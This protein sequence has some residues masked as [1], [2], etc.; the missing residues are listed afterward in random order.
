MVSILG[1]PAPGG[2]K[3]GRVLRKN[4]KIVM[5]ADGSGPVV[6]VH[7]SSKGTKPWMDTVAAV[8][9]S[10]WGDPEVR[11]PVDGPVEA[12]VTFYFDPG[13]AGAKKMR[14]WP[15]TAGSDLD[16]LLRSTLDP[17]TKVVFTNDRRIVRIVAERR[18][19]LPE[20]ADVEIVRLPDELEEQAA[21]EPQLALA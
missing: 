2:S 21:E 20:R 1:K 6:L 3:I 8:V 5:K 17:F 18:Y 14:L 9:R 7:P 12:R 16:K 11:E 13:K 4:G 10:Q 19:G 15:K